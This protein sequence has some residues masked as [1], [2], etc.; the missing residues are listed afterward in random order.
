[1]KIGIPEALLFQRYEPFVR[2]FFDNLEVDAVYSGPSNRDILERGIRYCVDEACLPIK[3]FQGHVSKLQ[4]ECDKV[5]VPRLMKCEFGDSICPKF[6]GL[7]ELVGKGRMGGK[8]I[9][10]EPLYL[11]DRNKL[12]KAVIK[13]RKQI[14]A[15]KAKVEKAFRAVEGLACVRTQGNGRKAETAIAD[16]GG[17]GNMEGEMGISDSVSRVALL[18]HP[19]NIFD[20]FANM[21]LIS[22]LK[23]LGV[24]PVTGEELSREDMDGQLTGLM[25]APYWLFYK[26]NFGKA[27]AMLKKG[28]VDG[29]LYV[30]SFC[31]GTDSV[32]IEM[33]KSRIGDFPMLVLKLDEHTAEAGVD[34]R[35]EAF[36]ELLERRRKL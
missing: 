12:R 26:E 33:I 13:Q 20:P 6:A 29:I 15:S 17:I 16:N 27:M 31:C 19:Y 4:E 21:N 2:A 35:L 22:K 32:T 23:R 28:G 36:A 24:R 8:I 1:M 25:K 3:I 5:I 14:G 11:N 9:F 18:G 30:S 10:T 34:T 7:P